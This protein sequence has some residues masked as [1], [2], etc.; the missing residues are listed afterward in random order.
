HAL[1]AA[2]RSS[3]ST[4]G[5]A[6]AVAGRASIATSPATS[7][8][9]FMWVTTRA[10][11]EG[12]GVMTEPQAAE[13]VRVGDAATRAP[14]GDALLVERMRAGSE[15]AFEAAYDRYAPSIMSFCRYMLG[16]IEE[17]E[18]AVQQTFVSAWNALQGAD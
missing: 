16:S 10:Q 15:A 6:D 9:F 8:I 18:D 7:V 12:S 17:A 4:V 11:E 2:R 1:M 13:S 3:R 5:C 14:V